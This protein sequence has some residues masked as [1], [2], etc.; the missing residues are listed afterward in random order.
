MNT[1][2]IIN[3]NIYDIEDDIEMSFI[4][5]DKIARNMGYELN[6]ERR[7]EALTIYTIKVL[8]FNNGDTYL[9]FD[10]SYESDLDKAIEIIDKS[11]SNYIQEFCR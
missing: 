5:L 9:Y 1:M 6:D 3:N 7:L 11:I 8:T 10:V 2:D 4:E